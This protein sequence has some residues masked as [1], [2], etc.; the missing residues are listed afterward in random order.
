M[1]PRPLS[2]TVLSSL[3][4]WFSTARAQVPQILHHQG[5]IAVTGANFDGTGQFKFALVDGNGTTT[6]W[7]NDGTSSGGGQPV[8]A[9]S[10][11]VAKGLYSVLLGDTSL[12]NM[13][14]LP[15]TVFTHNDVRLRIWFQDGAH[16]WQ[17]LTPDQRLVAVGYA[18][19]ANSAVSAQTVPD[20]AIT[21]AKI[22]VGAV[23]SAQLASNLSVTG[24]LSAASFT[25]D[26]SGLTNLP[27]SGTAPAVNPL[28]IAI[29]RWYP[30]NRAAVISS[31]GSAPSGMA[32]DG[33]HLWVA[34][35]N[36]NQ[37]AKIRA[38]D[39]SLLGAVPAGS[40]PLALCFDGA[41][42]WISNEIGGLVKLRAG[43]G[44]LLT[45]NPAV[46]ASYFACL[47]DGSNVWTCDID[48]SGKIYKINPADAS[49]AGT[50]NCGMRGGLGGAVFDGTHLWVA[51]KSGTSASATGKVAKVRPADGSVVNTYTVGPAGADPRGIT[52]D[53]ENIWVAN[54]GAG[55]VAKLRA[56]DGTILGTYPVSSAPWDILFDGKEIWVADN[57]GNSVR[58]LRSSDGSILGTYPVPGPFR[59][60]FD[61]TNVWASN[62]TT[63]QLTKL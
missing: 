9:V 33:I 4:L 14:A 54:Q 24:N 50:Y 27:A 3:L 21:A 57:A 29:N 20:G 48:G 10:L 63:N 39:G 47:F 25:G 35:S 18:L 17:R 5:R 41:N 46:P 59:L 11:P 61:G 58:R 8:A 60:A 30:A 26:G 19:V 40:R 56:A 62:V 44:A 42:I 51:G 7:S 36:S 23:G 32:F 49:I 38:A 55:T 34:N 12:P 28:R 1:I 2:C 31:S 37:V 53:G 16:G 15:A 52:F 6:Y 45:S 43:D 22:A 13:S